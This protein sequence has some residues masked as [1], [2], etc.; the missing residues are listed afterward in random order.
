MKDHIFSFVWAAI[1]AWATVWILVY[2]NSK[3]QFNGDFIFPAITDFLHG[4]G[5]SVRKV[6]FWSF[7]LVY[8][9]TGLHKLIGTALRVAIGWI[10]LIFIASV[11][12]I[13]GYYFLKWISGTV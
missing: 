11:V 2:L 4:R 13:A 1:C 5:F 9:L 6:C 8:W 10:A 3:L 7:F 12:V